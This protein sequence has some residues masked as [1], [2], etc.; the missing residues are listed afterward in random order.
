MSLIWE[1]FFVVAR[2]LKQLILLICVLKDFV[3]RC[4]C[5]G[6]STPFFSSPLVRSLCDGEARISRVWVLAMRQGA[7]VTGSNAVFDRMKGME[8]FFQGFDQVVP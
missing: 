1:V 2:V 8:V 3:A 6:F 5:G 7:V 4:Q